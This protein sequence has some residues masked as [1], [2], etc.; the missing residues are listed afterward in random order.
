MRLDESGLC[1]CDLRLCFLYCLE[2][3]FVI[4]Q[5]TYVFT[6]AGVWAGQVGNQSV[7]RCMCV[8][9]CVCVCVCVTASR[10]MFQVCSCVFMCATASSHAIRVLCVYVCSLLCVCDCACEF[11]RVCVWVSSCVCVCVCVCVSVYV[12]V[13]CL[14]YTSERTRV[15]GESCVAFCA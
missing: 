1:A 15:R 10:L 9:V 7:M 2:F 12:C 4:L 14:L 11:A 13:L 6:H 8:H 5:F 3:R